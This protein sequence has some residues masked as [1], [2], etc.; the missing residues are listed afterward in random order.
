M[1]GSSTVQGKQRDAS[2]H[3]QAVAGAQ[4]KTNSSS[5]SVWLPYRSDN[6]SQNDSKQASRKGTQPRGRPGLDGRG[7]IMS[8]VATHMQTPNSPNALAL[9]PARIPRNAEDKLR[10]K[11]RSIAS[12]E[13]ITSVTRCVH[14]G[15]TLMTP[16]ARALFPRPAATR[17]FQITP[18]G[19]SSRTSPRNDAALLW[20]VIVSLASRDRRSRN[21]AWRN[22]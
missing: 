18:P 16:P 4:T 10:G 13:I 14:I 9:F 7:S 21:S 19:A 3:W 2:F 5:T 11:G 1:I 6:A 22:R 17:A 15:Q 8:P 20:P 12:D